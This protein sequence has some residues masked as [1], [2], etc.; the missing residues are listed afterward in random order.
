MNKPNKASSLIKGKGF[1]VIAAAVILGAAFTSYLAI[2]NMMHKLQTAPNSAMEEKQWGIEDTEVEKKQNDVPK[3]SAASSL[4]QKPQDSPSASL[5]PSDAQGVSPEPPASP[6][7]LYK[8]PMSS[9]ATVPFS[10][11]ELVY[12]ETMSDWR[13]HNGQDYAGSVNDFVAAPMDSEVTAIYDDALWGRCIELKGSEV[14]MRL[15]GLNT[16]DVVQVGDIVVQGASIGSLGE[17]PCEA[18]QGT[19]LHIEVL[20][21]GMEQNPADYF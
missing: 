18:A 6:T 20:K 15:M 13:T 1:Y 16:K 11:N 2:N 3:S 21:D 10:G 17:L 19:H 8:P 5:K 9:A 7:A 14:T 4:P 12:S